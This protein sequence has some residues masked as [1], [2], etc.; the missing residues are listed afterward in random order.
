MLMRLTICHRHRV[1]REGLKSIVTD[2]EGVEVVDE[3][4]HAA[5]LLDLL[6][7]VRTD[8]VLL[9]LD[10]PGISG[11]QLLEQ[12]KNRVPEVRILALSMNDEPACAWKAIQLG[13][14]GYVSKEADGAELVQALRLVADGYPYVPK[15]LAGSPL[16]PVTDP[17]CGGH[18]HLSPQRLDILQLL[19]QGL[20]NKQIARNLG[21]SEG[22]VKSHLRVVYSQLDATS[23]TEA[24]AAALRL[25][26]VD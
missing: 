14:S 2:L 25:G 20:R 3:A 11:F 4:D 23:R 18:P 5:A 9:D 22:T 15:G 8:V 19:T 21:V 1:F 6:E 12:V 26:V 7:E 24:V 16:D 13:A 10:M 17:S